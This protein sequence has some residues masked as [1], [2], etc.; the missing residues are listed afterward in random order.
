MFINLLRLKSQKTAVAF[1]LRRKNLSYP[2][3]H[4]V[5]DLLRSCE[6]LSQ[7]LDSAPNQLY[8]VVI[9]FESVPEGAV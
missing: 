9:S 6:L 1:L 4:I 2:R 7:M 3:N 8:R 5:V